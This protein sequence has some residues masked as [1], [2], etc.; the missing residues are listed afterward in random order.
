[1]LGSARASGFQRPLIIVVAAV[2]LI[3][4]FVVL[5]P[6]SGG[7]QDRSFDLAVSADGM[8]PR[9]LKVIEGDRI[10]L[11]ISARHEVRFHLHGYDLKAE[12]R[13]GSPATLEFRADRTGRFEIEDETTEKEL[14]ALIVEPR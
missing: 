11:R 13:P 7:P 10:T 5:R 2:A 14:G 3:A 4:L 1:M 6:T 9:E 8:T 12:V